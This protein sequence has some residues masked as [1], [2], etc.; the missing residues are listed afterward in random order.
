LERGKMRQ[1]KATDLKMKE[2]RGKLEVPK[3]LRLQ[4]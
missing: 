2:T 1:S 4:A 3:D